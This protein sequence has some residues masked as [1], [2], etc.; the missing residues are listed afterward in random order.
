MLLFFRVID[1]LMV[2]AGLRI[3]LMCARFDLTSFVYGV[4]GFNWCSLEQI[5]FDFWWYFQILV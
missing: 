5:S 4:Q 2:A 1:L 3:I